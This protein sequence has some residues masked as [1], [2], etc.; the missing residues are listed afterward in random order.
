MK[1]LT[2]QDG[3]RL[4]TGRL[5]LHPT[6]RVG[7]LEQKGV[8]GSTLSVREEVKSRMDKLVKA[9]AAMDAAE[10]EMEACC[11]ED[12]ASLE[13]C[14]MV[15]SDAQ[16]DFE[17]AGGYT[18]EERVS[19]VLKGLGFKEDDFDRLCSDFSGGWQMRIALARLLLSEPE[20]LILDEPSNHLDAAARKWLSQYM[21]NYSGTVLLVSHDEAL[22][23]SAATSIAEIRNRRLDL[24]KSRKYSQWLVER[25]EREERRIA[26]YEKQQAEIAHLQSFVDRF[27]A[28]A[29]KASQVCS[30]PFA[31][32]CLHLRAPLLLP[33]LHPPVLKALEELG[34]RAL[35]HITLRSMGIM[36]VFTSQC[37]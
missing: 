23:E 22:L 3:V 12:S 14:A 28:S 30:L 6:W 26:E 11:T 25:E 24:Y 19:K 36:L 10:A 7:M 34:D 33:L 18:V 29:T 35:V 32:S 8:S 15:Y 5:A 31:L 20:L 27:G 9:L 4:S 2:G 16:A 37:V 21:R 13:E 1:A 17:A